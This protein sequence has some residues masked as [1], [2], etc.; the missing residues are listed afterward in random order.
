M[1]LGRIPAP[2]VAGPV[3]PTGPTGATGDSG[4]TGSTGA[5][6]PTG[7]AIVARNTVTGTTYALVIGDAFD[8]I[9]VDASAA[10]TLTVPADSSVN[11]AN[12]TEI[13]IAQ[14]GTGQI[15]ITGASGVTVQATPGKKFRAQWSAATLIKR[16]TDS[17]LLIGDLAS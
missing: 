16:T 11:F 2:N 12:L 3:G 13:H 9:E 4:P 6:G 1:S 8:L 10:F 14:V 5:T 7:A 17:W 15:T